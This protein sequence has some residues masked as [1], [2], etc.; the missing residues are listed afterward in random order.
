MTQHHGHPMP[1]PRTDATASE[2]AAWC[3]EP[4]PP[5]PER[6]EAHL[7]LWLRRET[8]EAELTYLRTQYRAAS[9]AERREITERA[10]M[11]KASMNNL[12]ERLNQLRPLEAIAA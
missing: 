1:Q 5:L 10:G 12:T 8:L 7:D 4:V 9:D 6:L 11:A 3:R 2:L